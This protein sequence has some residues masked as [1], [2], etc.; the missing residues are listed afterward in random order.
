MWAFAGMPEGALFGFAGGKM[1][2]EFVFPTLR[3]SAR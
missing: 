1:A 2:V 3:K